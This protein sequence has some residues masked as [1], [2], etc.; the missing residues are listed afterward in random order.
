MIERA[1]KR[2]LRRRLGVSAAAL[3]VACTSCSPGEVVPPVQQIEDDGNTVFPIP[4][5]D[6]KLLPDQTS[7]VDVARYLEAL[8]KGSVTGVRQI[9][10]KE[11]VDAV[12][13]GNLVMSIEVGDDEL[14]PDA[15]SGQQL[16]A[17]CLKVGGDVENLSA[18]RFPSTESG[19]ACVIASQQAG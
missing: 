6:S 11:Y 13:R 15:T 16:R 10:Y 9:S 8:E 4:D 17:A 3:I 7:Q 12:L 2:K 5:P 1:P 14:K 19:P 18:D